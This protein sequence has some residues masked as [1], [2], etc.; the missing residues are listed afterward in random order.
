M[1]VALLASVVAF[2]ILSADMSAAR[3]EVCSVAPILDAL[4]AAA[5]ARALSPFGP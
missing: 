3:R 1:R 5:G 4:E 2:A